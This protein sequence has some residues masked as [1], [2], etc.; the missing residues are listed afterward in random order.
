MQITVVRPEELGEGELSIWRGFQRSEPALANPFLAPEFTCAA[1]RVRRQ[2]RVAVLADGGRIVGF[3]PF[4]RHALGVGVPVAPG[5][6]GCQ[7]LVHEAGLEWDPQQ[8]MR[9]CRLVVW[10]FD[11]LLNAQRPFVAYHQSELPSPIMDV[12]GGYDEFLSRQR[13]KAAAAD[14]KHRGVSLRELATKERRLARD[15]G[16]LR[17]V[18]D[19]TDPRALHTLMAWKSSQCQR[20][21]AI[22][23]FSRRWVMQLMEELMGCTTDYFAGLQSELYAGDQLVALHFGL[24]AGPVLAGWHLTYNRELPKYSPGLIQILQ[25]ARSAADAGIERIDMGA[26]AASYKEMFSSGEVMVAAGEVV[27]RSAASGPRMV[28]YASE[29]SLRRFTRRHSALFRAAQSVRTQGAR[30]DSY[31]RRGM[32]GRPASRSEAGS[33]R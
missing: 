30:I 20:T 17:F 12:S 7:G 18:L 33:V 32:G 29:R 19:S 24:R 16:E 10:K 15:V 13:A 21:G 23:V 26:G 5:V 22:D 11:R 28:R 14:H 2:T 27:R 3:L 6:N 9:A 25:L 1:G 4:E 8:L 31:V